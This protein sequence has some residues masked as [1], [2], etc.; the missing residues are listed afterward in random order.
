MVNQFRRLSARGSGALS[1][2]RLEASADELRK[3]LGPAA[4]T[5]GPRRVLLGPEGAAFD[6]GIFWLR[7]D[8]AAELHL[9][10]GP[11][12]AQALCAWLIEH[13]WQ[14]AP[15]VAP[16]HSQP[17]EIPDA[18][19]ARSRFLHAESPRS[20]QAWTE[21]LRRD[22]PH[23]LAEGAD[24]PDSRRAHWARQQLQHGSWAEAW[25]CPPNLVL[26]G[27]PN[28]GKS[29]IFNA[30]LRAARATV[31]DAPGTTRDLVGERLLLGRGSRA[32][33]LQLMDTAGLWDAAEGADV[34]AIQRTKS[35]IASAWK[36]LWV[37]D[38]AEPP[39]R[40]LLA[41]LNQARQGDLF[42]LHRDDLRPSWDIS[43]LT[44]GPWLRGSIQRDGQN[45]LT[46]LEAALALSLGDEP[47]FDAWLPLGRALRGQ[48]QAWSDA[49]RPGG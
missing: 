25:E 47:P 29:S 7:P 33:S 6:E 18:A 5:A 9:H 32:W 36:V 17:P 4:D 3:L 42:L 31:A 19:E 43:V 45:L 24:L 46:R 21:F 11:G 41:A 14:E 44:G 38:V 2:W 15:A 30:W 39:G 35:A 8:G 48:L 34:L 26:A 22:G 12:V 1:C 10:G 49:G 16:L 23:T 28:A 20:A 27:Q 37:L 40:H 13:G